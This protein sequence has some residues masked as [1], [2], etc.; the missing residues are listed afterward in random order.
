MLETRLPGG[1]VCTASEGDGSGKKYLR[2]DVTI[3]LLSNLNFRMELKKATLVAKTKDP[4]STIVVF[5]RARIKRN[6]VS[7]QFS[8]TV[9]TREMQE[10]MIWKDKKKAMNF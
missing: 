10:S 5:R 6:D 2:E 9:F 4:N 3:K 1:F 7:V 8:S